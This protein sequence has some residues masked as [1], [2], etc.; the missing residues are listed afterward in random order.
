MP[1]L[2]EAYSR[3][4]LFYSS[5]V[6]SNPDAFDSIDLQFGQIQAA[7]SWL[8][9]QTTSHHV[10]LLLSL[11]RTL[12]PYLQRRG[13]NADLLDYCEHALEVAKQL[14]TN[15]GWLYLLKYEALWALGEWRNALIAVQAAIAITQESDPGV[16]ARAVLAL[17]RLQLNLGQYRQALP[18]LASAEKLLT[19][20]HD[21]DGVAAAKAEVAA[22]FLNRDEYKKALDLY[23]EVDKLRRQANPAVT[24]NHT[25]LMLGVVYR[26]LRDYERSKQSLNELIR[27]GESQQDRGALATGK[28]HLAWVYCDLREWEKAEELGAEAKK[29]YEDLKDPRGSSDADEQLGLITLGKRDFATAE[30]FLTRSLTVRQQLD[31]RHGAASSLRRLAKLHL[32]RSHLL[33]AMQ[34]LWQSLSL[35]YQLGVLSY[36]RLVKVF[37][38]LFE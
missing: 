29:L 8:I 24:S 22:Y 30:M 11:V 26:R 23:L 34:C 15:L 17:G 33:L 9:K 13:L 38:D 18:T 1:G 32:A 3:H 19:D 2:T 7:I 10:Q 31:N 28:H 35:Y 6:Q 25:L 4:C 5:C 21:Y 36:Q 37:I 16:H 20:V 14:G 12:S 27:H